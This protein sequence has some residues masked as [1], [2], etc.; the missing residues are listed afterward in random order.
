MGEHALAA[1]EDGLVKGKDAQ[2]GYRLLM[3]IGAVP[4]PLE[5]ALIRANQEV[6]KKESLNEWER[7]LVGDEEGL[8]GQALI[9]FGRMMQER[10]KI[11]DL[12][13]LTVRKSATTRLSRP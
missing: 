11:Y 10:A 8:K 5:R 12:K 13:L 4:S 7:A 9:G 3:D 2:L 1:V 6:V